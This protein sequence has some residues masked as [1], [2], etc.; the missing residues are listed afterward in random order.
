MIVNPG[1]FI[2]QII[3]FD[4][5][6]K[7]KDPISNVRFYCKDDPTTAVKIRKDQVGAGGRRS[8]FPLTSDRDLRH[9]TDAA[10][11]S[12]FQV[13]KLLP[14]TFSEQLIRVYYKKR[15]E[16]LEAAKKKFVQ[17]CMNHD[18]SKP[19]VGSQLFLFHI[20]VKNV[21]FL[22]KVV[23]QVISLL[24]SLTHKQFRCYCYMSHM[25]TVQ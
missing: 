22:V 15:D 10:T 13:S 11:A 24:L 16:T 23:L 5:G 8:T 20:V 17:W 18:F 3:T 19:Q 12:L 4:Y 25:A 7:D 2:T 21:F 1:V 6:M 9:V 14:E